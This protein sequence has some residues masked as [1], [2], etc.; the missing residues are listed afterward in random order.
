M[1]IIFMGTPDFSAIVLEKLNEVY[2]VSHVVTGLDK[3]VGRGYGVKFSPL[4]Q[5]AL[6]LSIDVLQFDK[7]S[8]EGLD[9]ISALKPDLVVTAAFGQILSEKFLSI[10]KYGVLNVHASLLP[11]FRGASP[12]QWAILSGEEESGVTIMRTVKEVDAGDILLQKRVKISPDDTA[13]S[14]FLKLA[15][16]G[17]EAIV[18]AVELIES[19]KAKFVSQDANL[20][21]HT[22]MIKK[23]DGLIN[24]D[25]TF[26]ELDCFVRGMTDWPS[27]FTHIDDKLLKVF[28]V[29]KVEFDEKKT[30]VAGEICNAD[31]KGGLIVKIKDGFMRLAQIQLEGAKR[32]SDVDFLKGRSLKVGSVLK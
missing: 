16:L 32:M 5:K 31:V 2:P 11:K 13:S 6:E 10:P 27:A 22:T 21:T 1:N 8:S 18:E 7:V 15:D 28:K 23:E 20:A 9:V 12:I 19:G 3:Q 25:R 26:F 17:G 29:Q 24:F 14:L 30:F 4:K